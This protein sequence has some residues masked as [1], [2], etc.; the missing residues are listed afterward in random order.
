MHQNTITNSLNFTNQDLQG[1]ELHEFPINDVK[2]LKDVAI[3]NNNPGN[4]I[5]PQSL[6][7]QE[8]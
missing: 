1:M 6:T 7:L 8:T 5:S 3:I 4:R 2:K